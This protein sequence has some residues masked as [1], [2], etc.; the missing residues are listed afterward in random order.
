MTIEE[1]QI[2]LED[3]IRTAKTAAILSNN[4]AQNSYGAGYDCGFKE[5]LEHVEL[6]LSGKLDT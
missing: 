1:I 2:W 3:E 5:A 6:F 4:I